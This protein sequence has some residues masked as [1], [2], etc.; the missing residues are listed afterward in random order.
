M[1]P[2]KEFKIDKLPF[3]SNINEMLSE[4]W[5]AQELWPIVYLLKETIP[6]NASAYVGETTDALN[7]FYQHISHPAK[8]MLSE[9]CLIT[10]NKF[11]KSATLDL[12]ASL[13]KYLA[14]DGKYQLLNS[15]V[16]LANHNYFQK[17]EVYAA[18]FRSVWD[19]LRK[20]GIA[21]HP[22]EFIDNSDLFKYSPYKSLSP[23]QIEALLVVLRSL[24]DDEYR[25]VFIEGGAGTGKSI[26]AVFLFK[27]LNTSM[28]DFSYIDF[29]AADEEIISLVRELK[30]KYPNPNMALIIPMAS[31]RKTVQ[32]IF[33]RVKGLKSNMV[34][35]PADLARQRYDIVLV[36]ESH[37]LRQR[38]NLGSYYRVF[39][40]VT[41]QFG[42]NKRLNTELD[43]VLKQ[44]DKTILFYDEDQSIKPSD[45]PKEAFDR[46]KD[47]SRTQTKFLNSQFRV[48]GGIKYVR[49]IEQL[50]SASVPKKQE[51]FSF[52]EYDFFL[53]HDLQA[54]I[55]HIKEKNDQYKLA[56]M[57][58]GYAWPWASRKNPK[59][60]DIHLQGLQLRWNS[61]NS[62]W[63]HSANA[64]NEIGC[65]HTTQG[66]DLNYTGLVFGPEIGYDKENQKII[67]RKE[68]YHD[69][70][71]KN[72]VK[73][74]EQL[75]NYILH[76]Y[77]T[78]MLR[79]IKGTYVFICDEALRE[80]FAQYVPGIEDKM[81]R[82]IRSRKEMSVRPYV[83][84][85]PLYNLQAAAGSFS[86]LQQ[87]DEHH[88][89]W[90]LVPENVKISNEYFA[91]WV[92]GESM[93]RIIPNN[94][95]CLF[96]KYTG[97][98]R[99]GKIVLVEHNGFLEGEIGSNYT[100]KEYHSKK[101]FD[102]D[103]TWTHEHILLK[104]LSNDPAFEP[105]V[106]KEDELRQLR[107][108][109]VFECVL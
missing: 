97:G 82:N 12:E 65:I 26:L 9:A 29:G 53:F 4:Y 44:S 66:Y 70:N 99:N 90:A 3:N 37:R 47:Q 74:A 23:D 56:R 17:N 103:G 79:G 81:L 107:V 6:R 11:H 72:N 39:D 31:F 13:I 48:R 33:S 102:A 88:P 68:N 98:S 21:Q 28:A 40:Q 7:R 45:A 89:D 35:G 86:G 2:G 73:S 59:V 10:S 60:F 63:I 16:G 1:T 38:V 42:F 91:C 96:R 22:L 93:N 95:I 94:S 109:G 30:E 100:V 75:K 101:L 55:T 52:K 67:I 104:P 32:K 85:V 49:F 57:V 51:K 8:K 80:Y 105:I 108:V 14:G 15:N 78:L 76:I 20:M 54:L 27:L 24:L 69:R 106:L 92:R 36:D 61:V 62:D 34:I 43:W 19:E 5:Y 64:I 87:V 41:A 77:K 84:S 83:N 25:N 58:A 18:I 50:L 46:L 71:G